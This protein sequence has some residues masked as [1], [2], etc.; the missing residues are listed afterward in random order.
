MDRRT[1]S[2]R[3]S[4][5]PMRGRKPAA[6]PAPGPKPKA[7]PRLT[8][9]KKKRRPKVQPGRALAMQAQQA[10]LHEGTMATINEQVRTF[11]GQAPEHW[12]WDANP[13]S[14]RSLRA[15]EKYGEPAYWRSFM[16][17]EKSPLTIKRFQHQNFMGYMGQY[18]GLQ[19]KS[20]GRS[21]ALNGSEPLPGSGLSSIGTQGTRFVNKAGVWTAERA[22]GAGAAA[23]AG[24]QG[25]PI[26]PKGSAYEPRI[27]ARGEVVH[28]LRGQGEALGGVAQPAGGP[29]RDQG[30][31]G[32]Q[33]DIEAQKQLWG[34]PD[35][36]GF[37]PVFDPLHKVPKMIRGA[38]TMREKVAVLE[39]LN[40]A[41]RTKRQDLSTIKE[42]MQLTE[43][44]YGVQQTQRREGEYRTFMDY[45]DK[46][47]PAEVLT[48]VEGLLRG[49]PEQAKLFRDDPRRRSML[50]T[51]L[52]EKQAQR[53]TAISKADKSRLT[54]EIA[55]DKKEIATAT[56]RQTFTATLTGKQVFD[57]KANEYDTVPPAVPGWAADQK[58][59]EA[60]G[61][62]PEQAIRTIW[63]GEKDK[64]VGLR[65]VLRE[66]RKVLT[67]AGILKDDQWAVLAE[68]LWSEGMTPSL[69]SVVRKKGGEPLRWA[70]S[71]Y[72]KAHPQIQGPAGEY[73]PGQA[74]QS[75]PMSALPDD[76][77]A[78]V[79]EYTE[80]QAAGEYRPGSANP[81]PPETAAPAAPAAPAGTKKVWTPG[82]FTEA[83]KKALQQR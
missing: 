18:G 11:D 71:V 31:V 15:T 39:R 6:A 61:R 60:D 81:Y 83:K 51:A 64:S 54:A 5:I 19:T 20:A 49:D 66:T 4:G 26:G 79:Q 50:N 36:E 47:S 70:M 16:R 59:W 2:Q 46:A 24:P 13:A 78:A 44:V 33:A 37:K 10:G 77:K 75:G 23:P 30:G 43:E 82:D 17:N 21:G 14:Q 42:Y 73:G 76:D 53:R 69:R 3:Q 55:R 74:V 62:T 56:A 63:F 35:G 58:D 52:T 32:T 28:T 65:T 1:P 7:K 29:Q 45:L 34:V 72:E 25:R 57:S 38:K 22:P 8:L 68:M 67:K 9:P 80:R 40:H 41:S 48:G 12:P 27:G